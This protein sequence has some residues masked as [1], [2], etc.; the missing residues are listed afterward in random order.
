MTDLDWFRRLEDIWDAAIERP[1][2]ERAAFLRDAC[3]DDDTIRHELEATL[4]NVSRA[5]VFLEQPLAALAAQVMEHPTDAVLTGLRLNALAIGPLIGAG[6]MGQV[7]R[8]RDTELHRDVAIKVLAPEFANDA[9]RLV[10]FAREARVL[11]S[12]NHPNIAQI[13][14]LQSSG[15][16]TA[17]VM[18]L[19]DG[20]TLADRI[21]RGPIAV[22]EALPIARQIVEALEAAHEQGVIHRDLKPANIQVRAD[23]I[24]K[25]LDFGLAKSVHQTPDDA[26]ERMNPAVL[27]STPGVVLGSA[28]YMSPEQATQKPVDRR[29][30]MWALGCVLFEMLTASPAFAGHTSSE[31]LS[32][33][34]E[35]EPDW[36]V[37]PASTP[38]AILRLLRRCLE[39][40]ARR[41]LDSAAVARLEIDEAGRA[42]S[43]VVSNGSS[44][45][46]QRL[47][48]FLPFWLLIGAFVALLVIMTVVQR[49]RL[50]EQPRPLT[51]TAMTVDQ[52]NLGQPGVHFSLAPSG[53]TVVYSGSYG[54]AIVLFR[55]D[56]DR[57][58]PQP[59]VGTA[60]GS[61]VFFSRDGRRIGFETRSELWST[62]LD[63]G[64]PQ[65]LHSNHPLR[66]GSWGDGD[67]IVVGRVGS[68]LWMTS[69]AGGESRQVTIPAEG[70][71]HELPQ[72]L[73][74]G[75]GVLFTI[76][77][78]KTPPRAAVFLPGTG[79]TR[80]LFE[81]IGARFVHSGHVVFG[82][83]DKLWAVRFDLNSLQTRGNARPVRDDV[84]WSAAGYPQFTVDGDALA[85]VRANHRSTN[86]GKSVL[87]L[88]NRKGAAEILPLPPDNYLL[89]ALSPAGDRLVVQVGANRDLWTYD[90][91]RGTFTRLTSDRVVAYSAP[92]WTPDGSRVVFTTWFDGQVGLGSVSADGSGA[93]EMLARGIGMRSFERTHPSLLPD[94]S[95][96]IMT[97]LA[98]A[99]SGED[100]LML[101]LSGEARLET[102]LQGPGVERNPAIA[103]NGRFVA[104]NSDESGRAEVY[105]RPLPNVSARRW[106]VSTGGGA[107]PRWTRGGRE[108]VYQDG[109]GRTMSVTVQG[110]GVETVD[111]SKP[112]AL[113]TFG[114]EMV[115][116]RYGL[117]RG[118][119]VSSDGER[120]V[121][122]GVPTAQASASSAELVV[123]QHWVDEL[124]RL[125]PRDP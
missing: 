124:K 48:W 17:I 93:V 94:G 73:P 65:P 104:Y 9:D 21:A 89:G 35:G 38:A 71:R 50:S 109:Q 62:S 90:F 125:V 14:G 24:V 108:L 42:P 57:L 41:R 67:R 30:D 44:N 118:F 25:V 101:R 7:Y 39:K 13:H 66:G 12:L 59:I 49:A 102:L 98:P 45:T 36:K 32:K 20:E 116:I 19:V 103:P 63:G 51:V 37:V 121:F 64:T 5:E 43:A 112:Q 40:D 79:E 123:I 69:A 84:L 27:S 22:N 2:A 18:E 75:H 110:R 10:R 120:F 3:G 61:D 78:V 15:A 52:L 82:R 47:A 26:D 53:R 31:V 70:E 88:V 8:A 106:Q 97:G 81:G 80:D 55:R 33:I 92:T 87:T 119:D 46:R 58:D 83:H 56:L 86:L 16:V 4:A 96:A 111:F 60:G 29:V 85:Y 54:D 114:V 68:G 99:G 91:K 113:F 1:Q 100:L 122:F 95:G 105:V 115:E 34:A 107:A 28:A 11:A 74:G 76:L 72:L 6:G 77:G 117:D 23:G